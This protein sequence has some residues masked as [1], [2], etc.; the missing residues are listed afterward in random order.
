LKKPKKDINS[1][2]KLVPAQFFLKSTKKN[3]MSKQSSPPKELQPQIP[4]TPEEPTTNNKESPLQR[5]RSQ[6]ESLDH[7]AEI[8]EELQKLE[9]PGIAGTSGIHAKKRFFNQDVTIQTGIPDSPSQIAKIVHGTLKQNVSSLKQ[10]FIMIG[11]N[12]KL[13]Y[14]DVKISGSS[15][16]EKLKD[17]AKYFSMI[18]PTTMT[19]N[20][21]SM[22]YFIRKGVEKVE[23]ESMIEFN[24]YSLR[25]ISENAMKEIFP[26]F[27][28][29]N[30]K[31]VQAPQELPP[32]PECTIL[33]EYPEKKEKLVLRIDDFDFD[34]GGR[35]TRFMPNISIRMWKQG[36]NGWY[37]LPQGVTMSSYNFYFWVMAT[38]KFFVPSMK[39]IFDGLHAGLAQYI[40]QYSAEDND[41]DGLESGIDSVEIP[42]PN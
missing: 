16:D 4:L 23:N 38:I 17:V 8:L 42:F 21:Q 40:S 34:Y 32:K 20:S 28:T 22:K 31:R 18:I 15:E 33:E 14:P 9:K 29:I 7:E 11:G 35:R 27:K 24:E 26:Y 37:R 39:T 12:S 25:K 13:H 5:K 2:I 19:A 6:P 10:D 30:G 3:K 36:R 1:Y 41:D